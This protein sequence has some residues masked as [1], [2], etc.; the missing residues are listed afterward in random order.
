MEK[1]KTARQSLHGL[2]ER[3]GSV[4]ASNDVDLRSLY[5]RRM[6]GGTCGL[7]AAVRTAVSASAFGQVRKVLDDPD[8]LGRLI[9]FTSEGARHKAASRGRDADDRHRRWL[10]ALHP[11]RARW[12]IFE[13][14]TR[15]DGTRRDELEE[16]LAEAVRRLC[17]GPGA[18]VPPPIRQTQA[19]APRRPSGAASPTRIGRHSRRSPST[20]RAIGIRP[21]LHVAELWAGL[22][23]DKEL[24]VEWDCSWHLLLVDQAQ[25]VGG[26]L[27]ELT[28]SRLPGG[29]G[30]VYPHPFVNAYL[31]VGP[32]FRASLRQA[33]DIELRNADFDLLWSLRPVPRELRNQL[34]DHPWALLE[35]G[36]DG[37]SAGGAW[38][39]LLRAGAGEGAP[40]RD[41]RRHGGVRPSDRPP[42]RRSRRARPDRGPGR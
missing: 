17:P 1:P 40:G 22:F 13:L 6:A 4:P 35:G 10:S 21:L 11:L 19:H 25:E 16:G 39:C 30:A 20:G 2:L 3:G 32:A 27:A 28:L 37:P 14:A 38:A 5:F 33:A 24:P 12:R 36:V 23:R 15:E 9:A 8:L 26:I 7:A 31:Q 42:R 18:A 34:P 29:C 41:G